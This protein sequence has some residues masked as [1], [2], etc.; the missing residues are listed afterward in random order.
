MASG[1]MDLRQCYGGQSVRAAILWVQSLKMGQQLKHLNRLTAT[2]AVTS[3]I[4]LH[5]W[6]HRFA[7]NHAHSHRLA[8]PV[9]TQ[10]LRFGSHRFARS[11]DWKHTFAIR[12]SLVAWQAEENQRCR[13][14]VRQRGVETPAILPGFAKLW[15][16]LCKP[17]G[18]VT[19][20]VAR[21][22]VQGGKVMGIVAIVIAAGFR[23]QPG[24]E[25]T[26][27]YQP[28]GGGGGGGADV[29]CGAG[30]ASPGMAERR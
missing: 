20:A 29:G 15:F 30:V 8:G 26:S 2:T 28:S 1:L 4:G 9:D 7:V 14:R 21:I 27:F 5:G 13:L 16:Q 10:P 23:S 6:K 11:S 24:H 3:P 22:W 18:K 25:K 19:T 12:Q 17:I